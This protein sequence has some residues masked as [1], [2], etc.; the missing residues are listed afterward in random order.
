MATAHKHKKRSITLVRNILLVI[1]LALIPLIRFFSSNI[2]A[3]ILILATSAMIGFASFIVAIADSATATEKRSDKWGFTMCIPPA[4]II[5]LIV[6][7]A[8]MPPAEPIAPQNTASTRPLSATEMQQAIT[9]ESLLTGVN[10]VRAKNGANPLV[11]DERLT[12]S[13]ATK[14]Q[15]MVMGNYYA[16]D[17]PITGKHGYDYVRDQGI[18]SAISENLN[19]GYFTS[20]QQV[21]DSWSS[22]ESH[23]KAMIDPQYSMTGFATCIPGSDNTNT[24]IIVQHFASTPI[25]TYSQGYNSYYSAPSQTYNTSNI[26]KEL[27]DIL[28]KYRDPYNVGEVKARD[29]DLEG[30]TNAPSDTSDRQ[31]RINTCIDNLRR[32]NI[33]SSSSAYSQ[34]IQA[35]YGIQ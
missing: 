14:C 30:T 1:A 3:T 26:D 13:S 4:G 34:A 18:N 31:D 20:T 23:F 15:D 32:S 21:I 12:T 22:S 7:Y 2:E 28:A 19:K 11:I 35:C 29:V 10:Q 8:T 25:Q 16:H 6:V 9:P 33:P 5:M 24:L 17:N 27:D